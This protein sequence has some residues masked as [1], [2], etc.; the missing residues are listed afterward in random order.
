MEQSR[1]TQLLERKVCR[2][3]DCATQVAESLRTDAIHARAAGMARGLVYSYLQHGHIGLLLYSPCP[4]LNALLLLEHQQQFVGAGEEQPPDDVWA[5]VRA[6]IIAYYYAAQSVHPKLWNERLLH[7]PANTPT[8]QHYQHKHLWHNQRT[9]FIAAIQQ[10][11]GCTE[12][13]ATRLLDI[14]SQHGLPDLI[15]WR[16]GASGNQTR[17]T[18]EEQRYQHMLAHHLSSLHPDDRQE[19]E[20]MFRHL[21]AAMQQSKVA[22]PI[23]MLLNDYPSS[24][25]RRRLG[26][27]FWFGLSNI[28]QRRES[29]RHRRQ[30]QWYSSIGKQQQKRDTQRQQTHDD[31]ANRLVAAFAEQ[32]G[33]EARDA[34]TLLRDVITYGPLGLLPRAARMHALYQPLESWLALIKLGRLTGSVPWLQVVAQVNTYREQLGLPHHLS[35]Q[36][37]RV[38]FNSIAKPSYWH[39]GQGEAVARVRQRA[40]VHADRIP[41]LHATWVL[42]P[43]QMPITGQDNQMI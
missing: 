41:R 35:P 18:L 33:L 34:R 29:R 32:A 11:R 15:D 43:V 1:T 6:D 9:R 16:R 8:R 26:R 42:A 21:L 12:E 7:E 27:R 13:E 14:L 20:T 38:V 25:R 5:T 17:A 37:T 2:D 23:A 36:L 31:T 28:I 39:G 30:R 4:Y 19:I 24:H 3:E 22:L 10:Q 40:T